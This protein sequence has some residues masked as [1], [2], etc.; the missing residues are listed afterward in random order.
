M[1]AQVFRFKK[2]RALARGASFIAVVFWSLNYSSSFAQEATLIYTGSTHATLYPCHCPIEPDGGVARRATLIKQLRNDNPDILLLDSGNF[3]SSG[4][5]DENTQN[6]QLDMQRA[7]VNLRAMELMKYDAVNLGEDEFNFGEKFF[8]EN[9]DKFRLRFISANLKSEKVLPYI[10]KESAGIKF[11][12]IG[13]TNNKAKDKIKDIKI[14][15]PKIALKDSVAQLKVEGA[16]I[17]ILLSNLGE[18]EDAKLINE[19]SGIDIIIDG[20]VNSKKG[21]SFK[22]GKTIVLRPAWQ[23]RRLGKVVLNIQNKKI[24]DYKAEEIRV[25]EEISD[26]PEVLAILPRCFSDAECKKTGSI[27][28]CQNVGNSNARCLFREAQKVQLTLVLPKDCLVCDTKPMVNLLKK[29]FLGLKI[30]YLYYPEKN[31]LKLIKK[32]DIVG[33]PVFILDKEVEKAEGFNNLKSSL[34]ARGGLYIVKPEASGV[35]YFLKRKEIK[36][37]LDIFISLFDKNTFELLKVIDEFNPIIHFLAIKQ[38]N[39]FDAPNGAP[40]VEEDLRAVCVQK[41]YPDVFLRYISCR[42]KNISSSWWDDCLEGSEIDKIKVCA[43]GNEGVFLLEEN[44]RLNSEIK[45]MFG[46]TYLLDNKEIFSSDGV[47]AKEDLKKIIKR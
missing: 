33:L 1:A 26:A 28:S 38:G 40:E 5:L 4:L 45:I 37:R 3:F 23:G 14:I 12:I 20:Q 18:E 30:N 21:I 35:V 39:K 2:P 9:A 11:G 17:I 7:I 15:E 36:G 47:P 10:I 24:L 29:Q 32:L 46:P 44:S 27:G 22:L 19:M 43:R 25:S 13:L 41:Y 8:G 34:E 42:S 6:T 16:D 31:A